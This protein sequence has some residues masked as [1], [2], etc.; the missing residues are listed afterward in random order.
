M[1]LRTLL[2]AILILTCGPALAAPAAVRSA[3][4]AAPT[5]PMVFYIA[6]GAPDACGSGCDTWIAAEG[7]IDSA[8]A[9][10]FR[11]FLTK[12]RDRNLP[13]YFASPGGNL[14]Q[15]EAM[16]AMLRE[17][18]VVARVA[19]TVVRE[20]GFEAQNSDVCVKLKQSGRELHG[21][22][23]T[24]N[25][26]C[27]SA[28]PY[29]MLGATTREVAPDAL[30]A[31]HSP[32]VVAHFLGGTPPPQIQAEATARGV[33]RVDR[34]LMQYIL[35]MGAEPGLIVLART[36]KYEDMHLL[37]R[38]EI[39]R[40][41]IDRREF[42][43]TPWTFEN[44]GRGI[45]HKSAIQKNADGSFR[46]SQWRLLCF[47]ADQFEL[48]F[49]RQAVANALLPT[50]SISTGGPKP[51]YLSPATSRPAGGGDLWGLRMTKA[52]VQALA[53][54]PQFD[55]TETLQGTDGRRLAHSAKFSGGGLPR[56][57]DSLLA[58]CPA[59]NSIAA[60]QTMG[61]GDSTAK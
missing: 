59:P 52:S 26:M 35:K 25:A 48:D 61:S 34:M 42:V 33:E 37:T 39:Y 44:V 51:F 30:L 20:C 14:D 27:N 54:R 45:V 3:P 58:T 13:I 46:S 21:D 47:N 24:R 53:E 2:V 57:L 17:R 22:L 38:E 41:G 7:Q 18:P 19:R 49:Q 60:L 28:C 50:V 4:R 10:R 43:E 12:V 23:W 9:P 5:P 16:G 8:A 29:L 32:K 15:A 36:I 56:A 6:K 55:F 40:F 31:V 11:K 1:T